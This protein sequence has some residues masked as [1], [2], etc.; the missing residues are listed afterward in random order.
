MHPAA[1][2]PEISLAF[3]TAC[4]PVLPGVSYGTS[5][6]DTVHE[7]WKKRGKRLPERI[8]RLLFVAFMLAAALGPFVRS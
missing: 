6:A 3:A 8:L 2:S 4:G 7:M 5:T 1:R